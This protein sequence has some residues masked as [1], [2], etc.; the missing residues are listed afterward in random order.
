MTYTVISEPFKP[1]LVAQDGTEM[2]TGDV[3]GLHVDFTWGRDAEH[4]TYVG[5]WRR[6]RDLTLVMTPNT[7]EPFSGGL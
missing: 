1:S 6:A 5:P 7:H 4:A 3:L 2:G